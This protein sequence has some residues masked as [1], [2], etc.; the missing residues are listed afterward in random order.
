[1]YAQILV[2]PDIT[3]Q[4]ISTDVHVHVHDWKMSDKVSVS[5][6]NVCQVIDYSNTFLLMH[7]VLCVCV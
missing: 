6:C 1:M 2:E 7:I 3:H 5:D 4:I